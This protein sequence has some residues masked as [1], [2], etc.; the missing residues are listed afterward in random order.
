MRVAILDSCCVDL[1]GGINAVAR[2]QVDT[3]SIPVRLFFTEMIVAGEASF[4]SS[5][6]GFDVAARNGL[7]KSGNRG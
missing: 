7:S 1:F 3:F 5:R 4:K 2:D 6:L